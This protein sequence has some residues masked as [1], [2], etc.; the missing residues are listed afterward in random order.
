MMEHARTA[1]PRL[2]W[3]ADGTVSPDVRRLV[4]RGPLRGDRLRLHFGFDGWQGAPREVPLE[5]LAEGGYVAEISEVS[6]HLALDCVVTDGESW[7]NNQET[8]YRLWLT[9]DPFDAHLHVSGQG[10]GSLG[11]SALQTALTS[12]GIS[13][14]VAS[15]PGNQGVARA[16]AR[17]PILKGLVWVRPGVT[18]LSVV[19]Q[20]LSAGF[21]GLKFHPTVDDFPADDPD[22]DPYLEVAARR[23]IP[24]A[25]HS[26]PGDADPDHIRRLA[27]RFPTVP[28]LLYH[29]YLGPEEG[30]FRAIEHVRE[31]PNLYLETSWCRASQILHF[32]QELGPE[33][34]IFGSDASVDGS[35]HYRREPPNVEARET[36]NDGLLRL[37][38]ALEPAAAKLVMG[39]NARRLFGLRDRSVSPNRN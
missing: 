24:V 28:I 25:I 7:D 20:Y 6:G 33:K 32:V 5:P 9:V 29:T 4:Y 37:V 13:G 18:P 36:Y 26:A 17:A 31:Q 12:A 15:W 1:R 2:A 3:L 38:R 19:R 16:T 27:E 8:D 11:L 10:T 30:R 14:G 21:V 34:I 39:D 22:M 35:T 23:G